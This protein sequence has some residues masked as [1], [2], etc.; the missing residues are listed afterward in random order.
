MDSRIPGV[1]NVAPKPGVEMSQYVLDVA[2]IERVVQA[3]DAL[4]ALY[5]NRLNWMWRAMSLTTTR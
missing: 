4:I 5:C 2:E 3:K 1:L